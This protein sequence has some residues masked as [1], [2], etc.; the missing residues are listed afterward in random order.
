MYGGDLDWRSVADEAA[1]ATSAGEAL[2]VVTLALT[3]HADASEDERLP[4]D[5]LRIDLLFEL[6][7]VDDAI[8]AARKLRERGLITP[9]LAQRLG[10]L[11]VEAGEDEE[12][13]RVFSEIVEYD[14]SG[15]YTRRL[16]GDIFLRHGWFQEAYRQYQDLV[17]LSA[18]PTDV[19]R[20]AR[21]AAGAGRV[22]E[23][24]RLLR[25]VIGGEGRPG[26]DDPR[27][28][29]RLHAAVLLGELLASDDEQLPR[30]KLERELDRLQLFDT[31]TTWTIL[32]WADLEHDLTLGVEPLT[33]DADKAQIEAAKKAALRISNGR[34]AGDTGLWA[35]QTGGLDDLVVRHR[36]P[37]PARP[38]SFE[39][40]TITW[41]GE[42]FTAKRELGTIAAR[43][44]REREAPAATP[45]DDDD[46]SAATE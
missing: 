29:A 10:E 17:S 12:G 35:I 34:N 13:K 23:G 14:P 15:E 11:L 40:L 21:A 9:L 46:D 42:R 18:A 30:A 27:R 36:S 7:R 33:P 32:T 39:R 31:P 44:A 1:R 22:D 3:K 24:L 16:L 2:E 5:L 45:S 43:A 38:V 25:K 28:F 4:L 41:D 19:I 8:A 6:D 37:V 20:M 26:A